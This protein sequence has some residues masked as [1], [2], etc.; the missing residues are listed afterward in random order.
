MAD[1]LAALVAPGTQFNL[2][3][4]NVVVNHIW[5]EY[6]TAAP[7]DRYSGPTTEDSRVA[8]KIDF[9]KPVLAS[10]DRPRYPFRYHVVEETDVNRALRAKERLHLCFL[11]SAIATFEAKVEGDDYYACWQIVGAHGAA[12]RE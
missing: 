3:R 6:H 9:L 10:G 7:T 8:E 4:L 11:E 1:Q 12:I 2:L 5:Q